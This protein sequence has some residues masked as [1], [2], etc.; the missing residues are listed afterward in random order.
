MKKIIVLFFAILLGLLLSEFVLRF[1]DIVPYHLKNERSKI[2]STPKPLFSED[3]ILGYNYT[4]GNL[5]VTLNNEL[6]YQI[7]IDKNRIRI[8]PYSKPE[9]L[10]K[11]AIFGCSFFAGMGVNDNEV[12]SAQLQLLL[13]KYNVVNYSIPGHGMA[14]Q[15]I[16]LKNLIEK[17]AKPEFAIF[18]IASFHL[19]R[20]PGAKS[21]VKDFVTIDDVPLQFIRSQF[22]KE[23]DLRFE[24]MKIKKPYLGIRKYSALVNVINSTINKFEYSQDYLMNMQLALMD[25]AYNISV[26][27]DITPIFILIT[28]DDISD[29]IGQFLQDKNYPF[30]ISEV[31]YNTEDYNLS[32]YDAHPN[33][34]AHKIYA[35]EIY[36]YISNHY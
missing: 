36:N 12:L 1:F 11:I 32:P 33:A 20:N 18:E 34:L 28:K 22:D 15:Y 23:N 30:I 35:S 2:I 14:T 5:C 6:T 16:Q 13:N 17:G 25:S 21:Y 3:S 7:S 9:N 4:P 29:K 24:L 19:H 31:N 26:S 27:N 8:N 10:N